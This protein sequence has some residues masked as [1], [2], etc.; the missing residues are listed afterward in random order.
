MGFSRER[1]IELNALAESAIRDIAFPALEQL[2]E[3]PDEEFKAIRKFRPSK[4]W[5]APD[6]L[7]FTDI[8]AHYLQQK[9]ARAQW[10]LQSCECHE[11][12]EAAATTIRRSLEGEPSQIL[13]KDPLLR[14]LILSI[15]SVDDS[16]DRRRQSA[17]AAVRYLAD[18]SRIEYSDPSALVTHIY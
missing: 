9:H 4:R 14:L 5:P 6:G 7:E 16:M 18:G 1:V 11:L 8:R 3:L 17:I 2:Y 10:T 13:D 12:E 15:D